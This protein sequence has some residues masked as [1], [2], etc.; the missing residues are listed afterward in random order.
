VRF[1]LSGRLQRSRVATRAR[2]GLAF[3]QVVRRGARA[4]DAS[5]AAVAARVMWLR[6][7][8]GFEFDEA[9]V[10]GLA[11][12]AMPRA[13][14]AGYVSRHVNMAAQRRLNGGDM[15]GLVAEKLVFQ[16]YCEG[17]GIP[18]PPLLG[19][20][21]RAGAAWTPSGGGTPQADVS[22]DEL[23]GSFIVKPARGY[24]GEGVQLLT[25]EGGVLT[26]ADG[27]TTTLTGLV[28][29]LRAHPEFTSWLVQ[30]RLGSHPELVRLG[31]AETLHTVR[32]VTLVD[33][34]G[35]VEVL[36]SALR[37]GLGGGAVDNFHNGTLGNALALLDPDSGGATG[38]VIPRGDDCGFRV[39]P[40]LP[41]TALRADEVRVPGWAAVRDLAVRAATLMLPLR[42]L[43]WDVAVTHAGPVVIEANTRWGAAGLPSG[44]AVIR[45]LDAVAEGR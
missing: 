14:A 7:R 21:D 35:R 27:R 33:R 5:P 22:P 25:R 3:A 31:G 2:S 12:P 19:V 42:T 16:R 38:F 18:V 32:I 4:Y 10:L 28:S 8:G 39:S 45:R 11:D 24:E 26:H 6:R 29:E 34:C 1:R 17:V 20:V 23:P 36:W 44:A 37:L 40:I 30:E 41:G 43:G 9:L 15:P 13:E